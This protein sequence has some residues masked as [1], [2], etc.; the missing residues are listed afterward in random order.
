M[1]LASYTGWNLRMK[2]IGAPD[3]LYSMVGSYIPFART[4]I[5]RRNRKDPRESIEER[6]KSKRDYLE[7][8]TESARQL[9]Q[10]G[11]LLDDDVP[12]IRERASAEWDYVLTLN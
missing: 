6:Y 11:F 10:E 2:T 9:V 1:P 4:R 12:R 7:K 5:E 3:E 8:I